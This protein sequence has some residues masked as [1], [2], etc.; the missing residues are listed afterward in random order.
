MAVP[1]CSHSLFW[2]RWRGLGQCRTAAGTMHLLCRSNN[3]LWLLLLAWSWPPVL[4][5][6]ASLSF[7]ESSCWCY[8]VP[9][10]PGPMCEE[11][12]CRISCSQYRWWTDWSVWYCSH[13][14]QSCLWVAGGLL[15]WCSFQWLSVPHSY[16]ELCAY[17]FCLLWWWAGASMLY[18]G[19]LLACGWLGLLPSGDV[20]LKH[21]CGSIMSWFICATRRAVLHSWGFFLDVCCCDGYWFLIKEGVVGCALML[22]DAS[23]SHM[24]K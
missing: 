22:C 1:F 7:N 16:I 24:F 2:F 9:S 8:T 6:E 13:G 10:I 15:L 3:Q 17:W 5:S 19:R 20:W 21:Q 14:Q 23:F 4:F 12:S 18:R 11:S